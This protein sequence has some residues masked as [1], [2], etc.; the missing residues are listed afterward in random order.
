LNVRRPG[1]IFFRQAG[2]KQ[3]LSSNEYA[4][5]AFSAAHAGADLQADPGVNVKSWGYNPP[6]RF[7]L[8]GS[9]IFRCRSRS[10]WKLPLLS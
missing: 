10:G 4:G 6:E 7:G 2:A 3:I 8:Q 5:A 9:L 1:P